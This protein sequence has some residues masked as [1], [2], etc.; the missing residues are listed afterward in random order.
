MKTL[1]K[2]EKSLDNS[3]WNKNKTQIIFLYNYIVYLH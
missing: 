1:I 3:K 2:L